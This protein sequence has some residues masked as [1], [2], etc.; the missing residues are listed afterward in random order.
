MAR[1]KSKKQLK[2]E[3]EQRRKVFLSSIRVVILLLIVGFSSYFLV[4]KF[5]LSS[6]INKETAGFISFRN[7]MDG[8]QLILDEVKVLSDKKGM[9]NRNK[10]VV[11]FDILNDNADGNSYDIVIIPINNKIDLKYIK[12]YLVDENNKEVGYGN[13]YIAE[14]VD[15]GRIIHSGVLNKGNDHYK[16]KLWISDEYQGKDNIGNSYEVKTYL[17]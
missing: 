4:S 10:S 6:N 11:E 12:Y 14:E 3:K 15:N 13:L 17:K 5:I 2:K 9:S 7:A 1:R 8:T 16:L